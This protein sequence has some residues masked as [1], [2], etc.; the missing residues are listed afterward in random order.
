MAC[1]YVVAYPIAKLLDCVLGAQEGVIYRRAGNNDK[2][3][4]DRLNVI[5][6]RELV[7]LHGEGP[8]GTLSKDEVG[9]LRAVL[10]IRDKS[11][12][13]AMTGLSDVF[14][15]SHD[16]KLNKPILEQVN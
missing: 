14:M 11:V 5:E 8:D 2:N 3:V 7:T 13:N 16:T 6:L 4:L 1:I 12:T 10:E 9:I 15:L